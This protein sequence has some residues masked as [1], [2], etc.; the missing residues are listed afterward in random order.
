MGLFGRKDPERLLDQAREAFDAGE[1]EAAAELAAK[2]ERAADRAG[3]AELR[4]EAQVLRAAALNEL[5]HSAEALA[6]SDA[7]LAAEPEAVDAMVERGFALW[8]LLRLEEARAQLEEAV[9]REPEEAWAHHTLGLVAER[10]GERKEAERRF[11]KARQLAPDDFP[12]PV[13]LSQPEF[14][15]AVEAALAEIPPKVRAYLSNVA[16]AV[17]DLPSDDDLK[18][19]DPNLSPGILGIFRGAPHGQK[20]S[21]DPWSHFPSS[22]VLYQKNLERSAADRD[23]VVEQ[24]G[25]TLVH[26]VGHFLGLDEEELWARGLG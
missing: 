6:A 24:I 25:I 13:R 15:A 14:D 10:R 22:I 16:I 19:G 2:G 3:N 17:E 21:M 4:G 18:G 9:R 12:E 23:E 8:E 20:V 1:L 7:L 5:G 26:E 11:R